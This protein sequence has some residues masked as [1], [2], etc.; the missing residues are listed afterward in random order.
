MSAFDRLLEPDGYFASPFFRDMLRT[1][2][3]DEDLHEDDRVGPFRIVREL[4]RGGMGVVYLAERADG[5]FHQTVAL[6]WLP[7]TAMAP[8]NAALFRRER[9]FLAELS[10]PNIAR[11]IDGGQNEAGHLWFAM[12]C[13]EG[14]TIDLHAAQR[15]LDERARVA[16]MLPVVEAVEF[17]HGRLLIHRVIKPGNVMI[18]REGRPK[19][20]D[21]GI[22]GLAQEGAPAVAFTP[23]YASPEQRAMSG[24]GTASDVW[25]L[26]RLLETVLQAGDGSRP[27]AKDLRAIIRRAAS[28][29]PAERYPTATALRTDLQRFLARKPVQARGGGVAY[30]LRRLAQRHPFGAAATSAVVLAAVSALAGFLWYARTERESLRQARD[31]ADTISRFFR[32]DVLGESDPFGGSPS[33]TPLSSILE[34]SIAKAETRFADRPE[35]AGTIII[36]IGQTLHGRSQYSA[37]RHAAERAIAQLDRARPRNAELVGDAELLRASSELFGGQLLA[38]EAHLATLQHAFPIEEAPRRDI[39]YN[40]AIQRGILAMYTGRYTAC[41]DDFR[42][43]LDHV[44]YLSGDERDD[45]F[46]NLSKCESYLGLT[47]RALED[48]L[49]SLRL[50]IVATGEDSGDTALSRTVVALALSGEGKHD[51]AT[52][53]MRDAVQRLMRQ[54]GEAHS[55]TAGGMQQLGALYL[56]AD[57]PESAAPWLERA[58]AARSAIA[59]RQHPWTQSAIALHVTALLRAGQAERARA[60]ALETERASAQFALQPALVARMPYE[61]GLL[62]RALG[63]WSLQDG[64]PSRAVA[65]FE[66]ARALA[67][68]PDMRDRLDLRAVESGLGLALSRAGR[69]GDAMAAFTRAD[70]AQPRDRACASPL[71]RRAQ[72]EAARL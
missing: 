11:L 35:T 41:V 69:R 37:A 40:V 33:D 56:C 57:A 55:L 50:S 47:D 64:A 17:A 8:E 27:M 65:H 60:E 38:A 68:R 70:D 67:L 30:R 5:E 29:A 15:S 71:V 36:D 63:E 19:L 4:G 53:R 46:F 59:G 28:H 31:E 51:E 62:H 6:K 44:P 2:F 34:R 1:H 13:I 16:L 3:A 43:L 61:I 7:D 10:H 49:R 48:G 45:L 24:V 39:A 23:E 42:W 21:F 22:A 26:G 12:E 32:S 18:D 9:Q 66:R 72:V 14:T 58:I 25:Q 20:L 52:Q 54:L